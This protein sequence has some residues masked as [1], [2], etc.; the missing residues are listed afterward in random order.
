VRRA[1]VLSGGG[2]AGI[3]WEIGFLYGCERENPFLTPSLTGADLIVG[4]SAGSAAGAQISSGIDLEELFQRQLSEESSEIMV[5]VDEQILNRRIENAVI[6]LSESLAIRQRIGS[7]AVSTSTVEGRVRRSAIMARL[8]STSWPERS[9]LITAVDVAT[10][11]LIVF[12]KESG[13]DLVEAVAASCAVPGVWPPVEIGGRMFIDGG[14]RSLTNA[15]LAVDCDKVLVLTTSALDSPPRWG[16][17][18]SEVEVLAPAHVLVVYADNESRA[19]FGS[20]P[21]SP[22]SRPASAYAG[23]D[24]GQRNAETISEFWR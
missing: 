5:D 22:N 14:V 21:F 12:D 15:D 19:A 23:R 18:D 17:L 24:L 3:A 16:S 9:L 8:P 20:N 10:G 11:E 4:T 6:G 2:V 1:L 13:V 7:I